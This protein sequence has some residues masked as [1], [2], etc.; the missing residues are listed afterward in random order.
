MCSLCTPRL[1]LL[2]KAAVL[3]QRQSG[4]IQDLAHLGQPGLAQ[5]RRRRA[6][7]AGLGRGVDRV[8]LEQ[9]GRVQ[10]QPRQRGVDAPA[11]FFGAV[12][13]PHHPVGGMLLVVARFLQRLAGDGGEFGIA[14]IAQP[15]PQQLQPGGDDGVAQHGEGEVAALQLDDRR[16]QVV[17]FVAQEGELVFVVVLRAL[18]AGQREHAARLA[19]QVQRHVAQR[20][21]LFDDGRVAAPFAQAL[22]Q[23]QAGIADAQQVLQL[24]VGGELDGG[25]HH[26]WSTDSGSL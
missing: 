13:Q 9:L 21:V 5:L 7:A 23:D 4:L 18:V 10:P 17:A 19:D 25:L 6:Q 2:R 24:G 12:A 11:R 8:V 22:A 20:D 16:V 15:F 14:G 3:G 26:M 1:P